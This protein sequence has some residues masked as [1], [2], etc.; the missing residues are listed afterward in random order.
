VYVIAGVAGSKGTVKNEG[1]IVIPA[2]VWK[3]AVVMS[4]DQGLAHVRSAADVQ[5]IAAVMPNDAGVRNVNWESYKTTIDSVEALSGYDVLAALP[6][7][8]ERVVESGLTPRAPTAR[9][10]F[11]GE[12]LEGQ[13]LTFDATTSTDPDVGGPLKDALSF[14]WTI[15]GEAAGIGSTMAH[16]FAQDGAYQ[17]RLIVADHFGLADTTTTEVRV[18]NVLPTVA[19]F[20]GAILYAGETY[21]ATGRFTDP[22]ADAWTATVSYAGTS[23]ALA[24]QG[25]AFSLSHTYAT[26]GTYAATVSVRDDDGTGTGSASVEVRTALQGVDDL[27]TLL[28]SLGAGARTTSAGGSLDR[29]ELRSLQLKLDAAAAQLKSGNGG[30][31]ANILNAFLEQ[32]Q[33]FVAAGRLTQE[34]VAPLVTLARRVA[35]SAVR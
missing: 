10:T 30:A 15:D 8:I 21:R 3:V 27:S 1:K 19:S 14:A 20:D 16:T 22:G 11:Q 35:A 26:A 33:E 7:A 12:R 32:L 25:Q 18:A 29:G 2:Y 13:R 5:V 17:V 31:A 28:P 6:D 23:Q 4:R 24:L 34:R 9:F